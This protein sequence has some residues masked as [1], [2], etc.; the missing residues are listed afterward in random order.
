M[1]LPRRCP[2]CERAG[3]APCAPCAA[4]LRHGGTAAPV[5]GVDSVAAVFAYEGAVRELLLGLKYRNRRDSLAWLGAQLARAVTHPVDAVTWAPTS[6]RRARQ[7]G[8]D[9]AELLARRVARELSR[10]AVAMLRRST[11]APQT[12]LDAA[13]R[14]DGLEFAPRALAGSA[15]WGRVP[16]S[17][18][19]VDDVT[20]TG[21]T[22]AAAAAALHRGGVSHVHAVVVAQTPQHRAASA[23]QA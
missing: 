15:R 6:S 20:T 2:L 13:A 10:P 4:G 8:Y 21:A 9:Q 1:F 12:G 14:R 3:P 7:R 19:L 23:W 5:P 22:L 16:A 18:L 11:R 17:V